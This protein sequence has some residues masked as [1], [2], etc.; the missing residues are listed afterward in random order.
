MWCCDQGVCS[1]RNFAIWWQKKKAVANPTTDCF[2]KNCTKSPYFKE[3]QSQVVRFRPWRP[4]CLQE[5]YLDYSVFWGF[6]G[7]PVPSPKQFGEENFGQDLGKIKLSIYFVLWSAIDN[8]FR[9]NLG[10]WGTWWKHIGNSEENTKS[11]TP[12]PQKGE[13]WTPYLEWMLNFLIGCIKFL[14]PKLFVTIF[15]PVLME[16][17][18]TVG[19]SQPATWI[20]NLLVHPD[21]TMVCGLWALRSL[22]LLANMLPVIKNDLRLNSCRINQAIFTR[23]VV[24]KLISWCVSLFEY[25]PLQYLYSISM[26]RTMQ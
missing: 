23:L 2:A 19:H 5:H 10:I 7:L 20:P 16:G 8:V 15:W 9:N 6:G 22:L 21:N 4:G 13:N 12:P 1:W 11:P 26:M 24:D 3:E 17:A 14:F 25:W 18:Q